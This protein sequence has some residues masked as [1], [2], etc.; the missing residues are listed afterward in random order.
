V[1]NLS[2]NDNIATPIWLVHKMLEIADIKPGIYYAPNDPM[3]VNNED[4]ESIFDPCAGDNRFRERYVK[5]LKK[6][7][8]FLWTSIDIKSSHANVYPIDFFD[9]LEENTFDVAVLNPPFSN[10]GAVNFLAKL[11]EFFIASTGRVI[12]IFP[13]MQLLQQQAGYKRYQWLNKHLHRYWFIPPNTFQESGVKVCFAC[14]CEF[15]QT[16]PER[17]A[18][19]HPGLEQELI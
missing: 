7:E 12:M 9:Y 3:S 1:K 15:R 16:P 19:L 18:I 5:S 10:L 13:L 8:T 4:G 17:P 2:P 11:L 14:V 6:H